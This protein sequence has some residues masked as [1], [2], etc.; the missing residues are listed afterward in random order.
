M[1]A[2]DAQRGLSAI[3]LETA[4]RICHLISQ[5]PGMAY[6]LMSGDA[7]TAGLIVSHLGHFRISLLPRPRPTTRIRLSPRL[8]RKQRASAFSAAQ[9][10]R[11]SVKR[12]PHRDFRKLVDW[13]KPDHAAAGAIG[14]DVRIA[15]GGK[16]FEG[17]V[18]RVHS[19]ALR[20]VLQSLKCH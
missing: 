9:P 16:L 18:K 2:D 10:A 19:L 4:M 14:L 5:A 7:I 8:D 1:I 20:D 17:G 6:S 12:K 11:E 13:P 3:I 15:V